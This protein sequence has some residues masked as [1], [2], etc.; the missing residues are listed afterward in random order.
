LLNP[1][2][3]IREEPQLD[4]NWILGSPAPNIPADNFSAR[5]S[6]LIDFAEAGDYRFFAEADDGVR[7]YLDGWRVIDAWHTEPVT[8]HSGDFAGLKRGLHTVVVEYFESGAYAHLKV[9]FEKKNTV[10]DTWR[11]EYYNNGEWREPA[12]FVRQDGV[13]DFN[14]GDGS[15][16]S[17][18]DRNHFSIRW[19]RT[20]YFDQG[21]Y[22]FH[23]RI[24]DHDRV[25]IYLDGWLLVDKY[26]DTAGQVDAGFDQVGAGNHT[27]IVEY[28]DDVGAAE[29][30]VWWERRQ[31]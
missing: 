16:E 4:H 27:L 6:R 7:L 20:L 17:R 10:D 3:L 2:V 14:W 1:P 26:R 11:G 18:L 8:I 21:D 25:K 23:A 13:I 9:W 28:E 24:A 30:E 22:R 15:P 19:K 29:I 31:G 5:W 12:T